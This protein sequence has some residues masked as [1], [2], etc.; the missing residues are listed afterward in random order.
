MN[1]PMAFCLVLAV[2]AFAHIKSGSFSVKSG[3]VYTE[4]QS[5]TLS[6][7]ASIDHNKSNYNLWYSSDSG[8]TW[9]T[10]KMGIPGQTAGVLVTYAWT[11]PSQPTNTGMLRVFQVFGGTVATDPANPGDYTLFSPV[12]KIAATSA[13]AAPTALSLQASASL[14]PLGDRLDVRFSARDGRSASLEV[15][16]MDGSLRKTL[17]LASIRTGANRI[18]LPLAELGVRGQAIVRLRLDGDVVAEKIVGRLK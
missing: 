3:T 14:R 7:T 6:W 15:L 1:N 11:V 12:F 18:E 5:V 9:T 17:D 13:I 8:K 2:A 4:G 16:G 10:V